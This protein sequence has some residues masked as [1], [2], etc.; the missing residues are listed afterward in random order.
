MKIIPALALV[1]LCL[2]HSSFAAEQ[3]PQ[4]PAELNDWYTQPAPNKNA[5]PIFA[6]A[7]AKI[8]VSP[9]DQNLPT[10]PVFGKGKLPEPN[11]QLGLHIRAPINQWVAKNEAAYQ[12][13]LPALKLSESRYPIDLTHLGGTLLPHLALLKKGAQGLKLFAIQ[14]A[15]SEKPAD[16]VDALKLNFLIG[17]SLE[18][19]PLLISQLV[20][21]ACTTIACSSL[22]EAMSRATLPTAGLDELQSMLAR[23][24]D[25]FSN[26]KAFDRALVGE[27]VM[28]LGTLDA[29]AELDK[30][31]ASLNGREPIDTAKAK[32]NLKAE[33]AFVASSLDQV[34]AARKAPLPERLKKIQGLPNFQADAAAQGLVLSQAWVSS[35][36]FL[37]TARKEASVDSQVRLAR[38][39]IAVEHYRADQKSY[40]PNLAALVPKY[41]PKALSD[42]LTGEPIQYE[43]TSYGFHLKSSDETPAGGKPIK[44]DFTVATSS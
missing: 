36:N 28:A 7:C 13:L 29:P 26:G 1:V 38:T 12:S 23:A 35:T 43:K 2:A 24:D 31:L 25:D 44:H 22:E 11:Q 14:R 19:E 18:N 5:A 6:A 39:A 16:S 20:R 32:K 4:T 30:L 15:Y 34:V 41:L 27:E 33:R 10:L 42:P 21:V 37:S 17:Q 3:L 40:P 9:A 8:V